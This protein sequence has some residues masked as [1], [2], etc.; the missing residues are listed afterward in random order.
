MTT[1]T[2][3]VSRSRPHPLGAVPD[4][5]GVS[6]SV[7]S[8][9]ATGVELLLFE[10]HDDA[11]PAQ[12]VRLDPD[13]HRS[14]GF[15]HCHVEGV[16]PGAHYAYRIE[17]PFAPQQGHRFNPRKVLIDPYAR[18]NTNAL[19]NRVDACGDD[20][21]LSTSMRSVVIDV[22]DYDW[23]GDVPLNRPVEDSIIYEMHVGGFTR[24]ESSG[25]TC[26]GKFGGVIEKIPYLK[27]LG[28]TAVELMPV[29]EFDETEILQMAQD[30]TP[31][32]NYWG[33]ST[34]SFFAAESNYCVSPEMGDHL[35]EFRDMVK[36][37]HNAGIEVIMDVVFN[38]T[39]EGNHQGPM[40]NFKG[41]DNSI[42]YYLVDGQKQYYMGQLM[43][44]NEKWNAFVELQ[45]AEQQANGTGPQF[46][47][48]NLVASIEQTYVNEYGEQHN[49]TRD[50]GGMPQSA[51]I[52]GPDPSH[53]RTEF[54]V[55]ANVDFT[56]IE[57]LTLSAGVFVTD[58]SEENFR[59]NISTL[60]NQERGFDVK[61]VL[62]TR[63][64]D[65]GTENPQQWLDWID[66]YVDIRESAEKPNQAV[67]DP[68]DLRDFRFVRYSW[69]KRPLET[70]TKQ[71]R[72][73]A[74]YSFETGD[75]VKDAQMKHTFLLG[76]HYINDEADFVTGNGTLARQFANKKEIAT[77]D[78]LIERSIH[79]MSIIRYNGEPLAQPGNQ[80]RNACQ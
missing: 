76:Y 22:S 27:E 42:Y 41:F 28:V 23:E 26:P 36:A 9:H 5:S 52:T 45:Y 33:Y 21:N 11:K 65:P 18:G 15:W 20:D 2:A 80:A 66:A 62:Y 47:Y 24:A 30:G 44:Q 73:R 34:L 48:D 67:N 78:P 54:D 69:E 7:F 3:N 57:N 61:R 75:F 4:K 29:M 8:W 31:L 55:M 39:N 63:A 51:R 53:S 14:Y 60:N 68:R 1:T 71:A 72:L 59:I 64:D 58:A 38:H 46:I 35:N 37:L 70:S 49:W 6:F 19:W 10:E 13:I 43:F 17:G 12:T 56:P 77:D 40:I 50:L 74:T 32:M 25:V 79:D 16:K